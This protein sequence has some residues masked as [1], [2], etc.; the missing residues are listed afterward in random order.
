MIFHMYKY[1]LYTYTIKHA[2]TL[3]PWLCRKLIHK[4]GFKYIILQ[5]NCLK[6]NN[7]HEDAIKSD[8]FLQLIIILYNITIC[9]LFFFKTKFLMSQNHN[10]F[11]INHSNSL[12]N[13]NLTKKCKRTNS[14]LHCLRGPLLNS[15]IFFI[16]L[17]FSWVYY[18]LIIQINNF[19]NLH[20]NLNK[21]Q[22]FQLQLTE[23]CQLPYAYQVFLSF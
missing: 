17:F 2:Y 4:S 18:S 14:F 10:L 16:C 3:K 20:P 13:K 23:L 19:K 22:A 8:Y 12:C 9:I 7:F 6:I 21:I 11:F 1:A 5:I 15:G